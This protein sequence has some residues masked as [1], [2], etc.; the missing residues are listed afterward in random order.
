M[1]E[2]LFAS[3]FV[4]MPMVAVIYAIFFGYPSDLVSGMIVGAMIALFVRENFNVWRKEN[5]KH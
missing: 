3:W 5:R 4:L 1:K 2:L